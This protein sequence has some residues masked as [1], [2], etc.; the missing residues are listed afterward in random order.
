[1]IWQ[2]GAGGWVLFSHWGGDDNLLAR[3]RFAVR[4][5]GRLETAEV[6]LEGPPRLTGDTLRNVPLGQMEAW[7][8]GR[9]REDLIKRITKAE[10]KVEQATDRWLT[11]VGDGERGMVTL[12]GIT[13]EQLR[14]HALRVRVPDGSKRPNS[15]YE[16]VAELYSTLA[17]SG[18]RRPAAEIAEANQVPVTT[19]HRWIKEARARDLLGSGRRGKAG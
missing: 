4:A 17:A 12:L 11:T 18:S 5:D 14:R 3:V 15:F 2:P 6:H 13:L 9:E 8:N 1:M 19:V 16:K 10:A 7:A